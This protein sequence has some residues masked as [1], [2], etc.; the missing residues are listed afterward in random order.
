MSKHIDFYYELCVELDISDEKVIGAT[1]KEAQSTSTVVHLSDSFPMG[2]SDHLSD[3][4]LAD[5]PLLMYEAITL[6]T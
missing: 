5:Y 4:G 3:H 1:M 6:E 2:L